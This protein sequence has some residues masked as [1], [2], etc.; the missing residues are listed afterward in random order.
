MHPADLEKVLEIQS[1]DKGIEAYEENIKGRKPSELTPERRYIARGMDTLVPAIESVQEQWLQGKAFVG[2]GVWGQYV[3]GLPANKLALC[4]LSTLY[5]YAI[6]QNTYTHVAYQMGKAV[7]QLRQFESIRRGDNRYFHKALAHIPKMTPNRFRL[8]R[9]NYMGEITRMRT[10]HVISVGAKMLELAIEYTD[11]FDYRKFLTKENDQV[12][13]NTQIVL[14]QD[15]R[16]AIE[17]AHEDRSLLV[18]AYLPMV[19]PPVDWTTEFDG[20][21]LFLKSAAVKPVIGVR[22]N[23]HRQIRSGHIQPLLDCLNTLQ[24][25]PWM[26]EDENL[27]LLKEIF[28]N[29]GGRAG[30]PSVV[31]KRKP[32]LPPN[33]ET[34]EAAKKNWLKDASQV[35]KF[36]AQLTGQ[37]RLIK[38]QIDIAQLLQNIRKDHDIDT[39]YYAWEACFRYRAYPKSVQV[40][41]QASDTGRG[42]L[43]FKNAVLLGD[44]GLRWLK[45]GLANCIG[46]DKIS[47]D[48]R[49]EYINKHLKE[50]K[51]WVDNP[52]TYT[53]WMDIDEPFQGLTIAREVVSA[54]DS[55]HPSNFASRSPIGLDGTCN[56]MQ[57]YSALGRDL[58]G[59]RYTNLLKSDKPESLYLVVADAVNEIV[60]SDCRKQPKT[61]DE[62]DIHPCFVWQGK[63][64]KNLVKPGTMTTPYGV[65]G[66]GIIDQLYDLMVDTPLDG[67]N[68]KNMRYMKTCIQT[69]INEVMYSAGEIMAWLR[70]VATLAARK[71]KPLIW[72]GPNGIPVIQE[73]PNFAQSR[74]Y[75]AFQTITWKNP[76]KRDVA[77]PMSTS[78]N[79][80]SLP[81]NFVHNIDACH[82]MLTMKK[83][84]EVG[85]TDFRMIH[86]SFAVHAGH[87]ERFKS[88]INDAFVEIHRQNIL[89][90]FA[91]DIGKQLECDMPPVPDRG[92][93]NIEDV[94][95]STYLFN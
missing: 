2:G 25:T 78:K 20:G 36:N 79:R 46:Q 14:M 18:P 23:E 71:N 4:V 49:V 61:D 87:V 67:H 47:L 8:M 69:A 86:D 21:Y 34:D 3:S 55:G 53:G 26:L 89:T 13:W 58:A 52:R 41:P 24:R 85:I 60:E 54:I 77:N 83:A 9:R 29:G 6:E 59:A 72:S 48:E 43:K 80:N 93:L 91:E 73:Y 19:I 40:S 10:P 82:M 76:E 62:G 16:D 70:Q 28:Q 68:G 57:H 90:S 56:G 95:A 15:I 84:V 92:H 81:P 32:P 50:I 88:L 17:Q 22:N 30:V 94:L 33:F 75:T 12:R 63:I 31:R 35:H 51:Q 7:D 44:H 45:I 64:T 38:A 42:L 27:E 5:D 65:T 66:F 1:I 37:R 39:F 74:V 11:M